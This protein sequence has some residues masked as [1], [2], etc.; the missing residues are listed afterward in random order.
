MILFSESCDSS[1]LS[2]VSESIKV[3]SEYPEES[4]SPPFIPLSAVPPRVSWPPTSSCWW[5]VPRHTGTASLS[6]RRASGC[7]VT[8]GRGTSKKH[9]RPSQVVSGGKLNIQQTFDRLTCDGHA[10]CQTTAKM[11]SHGGENFT[12]CLGRRW[13]RGRHGRQAF[14]KPRFFKKIDFYPERH[15]KPP[16]EFASSKP[17]YPFHV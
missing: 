1:V 15:L 13:L 12:L 11:S 4:T 16:P 10:E 9:S 3:E 7:T 8:D 6:A 5:A 14:F 2:R 17:L